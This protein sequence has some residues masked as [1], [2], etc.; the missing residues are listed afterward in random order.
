M[1]KVDDILSAIPLLSFVPSGSLRSVGRNRWRG[2]CP[3]ADH[4]SLGTFSVALHADGHQIFQC[5][6]CGLRGSAID[7]FAALDGISVREAIAKLSGKDLPRISEGAILERAYDAIER[8]Y[9]KLALVACDTPG[10]DSRLSFDSWLD[11]VIAVASQS[12]GWDLG[13]DGSA[14][15]GACNVRRRN[16]GMGSNQTQRK[17]KGK[18]T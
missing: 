3:I 14:R 5:F 4:Q 8:S 18:G 11:F 13:S 9:P 10:C 2:K 6:A 17:T 15:C 16:E 7:L 1:S 12:G